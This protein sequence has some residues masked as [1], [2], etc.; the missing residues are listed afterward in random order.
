MMYVLIY[1]GLYLLYS[2][3]TLQKVKKLDENLTVEKQDLIIHE[4]PKRW[5]RGIMKR[6]GSNV[7]ISGLKSIPVGP[8]LFVANHAGDFDIPVLLGSIPKP[9]GFIS[10]IEVKK[11]PI[12]S[13]WMMMISC[14]FI[15]RK[16]RRQAVQS[17]RESVEVLKEGHSLLIF[18]EGTR[19]KGGGL[20]E[21]KTGGIRMAKDAGVPIVP[22]AIRGTADMFENQ[23]RG[24]KPCDIYVEI[25]PSLSSAY[26]AEADVKTLSIEVQGIIQASLDQTRKA[27]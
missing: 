18:P 16:N 4:L 27:S 5:S 6:T 10:K 8:V 9:F 15:D 11:L 19:N 2:I 21:F 23:R 17:I 24:I 14:I 20:K 1:M 7:H 13:D 3:P 22:I 12:I 25:L 26:V